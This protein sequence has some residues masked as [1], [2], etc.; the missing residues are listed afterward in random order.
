MD[1]T[2]ETIIGFDGT[3]DETSLVVMSRAPGGQWRV[4]NTDGPDAAALAGMVAAPPAHRGLAQQVNDWL[5][6]HL[7]DEF[8][9]DGEQRAFLERLY[10]DDWKA[11]RFCL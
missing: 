5:D 8:K 1:S 2:R 3:T 9:L 10:A 11:R 4:Q 7:G 6:E